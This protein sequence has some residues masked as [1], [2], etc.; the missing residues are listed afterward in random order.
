MTVSNRKRF[1]NVTNSWLFFFKGFRYL[2][3]LWVTG[4]ANRLLHFL[5]CSSLKQYI[6]TGNFLKIFWEPICYQLYS[7]ESGRNYSFSYNIDR[8]WRL[9]ELSSFYTVSTA[10]KSHEP[11]DLNPGSPTP[12]LGLGLGRA[13]LSSSS[14]TLPHHR[15]P[16]Q[17]FPLD[18]PSLF[19]FLLG[20][21]LPLACNQGGKCHC[22]RPEPILHFHSEIIFPFFRGLNC[23]A[24]VI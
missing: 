17:L 8:K 20:C 13:A 9:P 1:Q 14:P 3:Y 18:L 5:T 12:E 6:N 4:S 2:E 15:P 23:K 19:I 10:N 11:S 21:D 16:S 7:N 22:F 24:I